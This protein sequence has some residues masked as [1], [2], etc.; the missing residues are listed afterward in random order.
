LANPKS[1]PY[2][3]GHITK[4]RSTSSQFP[5]YCC[6]QPETWPTSRQTATSNKES[7]SKHADNYG[8]KHRNSKIASLLRIPR[9]SQQ[10]LMLTLLSE[11]KPCKLTNIHE[12]TQ[13]V[14]GWT[15]QNRANE[16]LLC[17]RY[18]IILRECFRSLYLSHP[19]SDTSYESRS[20]FEN[21]KEAMGIRN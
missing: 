10:A 8:N 20:D 4:K 14:S 16:T 2:T 1:N 9:R 15:T 12:E 5:T 19:K 13:D 7:E 3:T 17:K 6:K 18:F 21:S 11:L